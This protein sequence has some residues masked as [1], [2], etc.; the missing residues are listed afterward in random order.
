LKAE[1]LVDSLV[2][3][4]GLKAAATMGGKSVEGKV[5]YLAD[6]SAEKLVEQLVARRVK[7][8]VG[9]TVVM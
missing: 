7:S 9:L 4:W 5:D 1:L 2:G 8:M 3:S 6:A